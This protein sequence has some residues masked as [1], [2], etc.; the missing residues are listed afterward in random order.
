MIDD[1]SQ[2]LRATGPGRPDLRSHQL[3]QPN[4]R[5]AQSDTLS[6]P[7]HEPPRV[8]QND[9]IRVIRDDGVGGC[10][11]ETNNI[12]IRSKTFDKPKDRQW[13]DINCRF[14]SDRR[15]FSATNAGNMRVR[16]SPANVFNNFPGQQV[17]RCLG[18][19]HVDARRAHR[20]VS[21]VKP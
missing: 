1:R 14:Y 18:G 9:N 12:A 5:C 2:R 21:G 4:I 8:D 16:I 19:D 20:P 11:G 10:I 13:T 3:Y 7:Q 6:N 17:A 15:K